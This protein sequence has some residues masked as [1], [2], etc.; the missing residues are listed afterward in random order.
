MVRGFMVCLAAL[1]GLGVAVGRVSAVDHSNEEG[2]KVIFDGK[3]MDGWKVVENPQSFT[4]QDGAMVAKG[5]RAHAFYVGDDKPFRN[6]ELKVDVMTKENSNGG[7]FFHT[8]V[9]ETGWPNQG[10]EVQ[11]NNTFEKDPR[12]TGSLYSVKDVMKVSPVGDNVWYTE[13]I[14][15]NGPKVTV[16]VEGK[17]VV[18]WT[19]EK[20]VAPGEKLKNRVGEGTFAL[21][22]HDPGSTV[23]YKNIRVKRLPD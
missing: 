11:V 4:L 23:Y 9:Q 16:K 10:F 19:D 13:H 18:E 22:A 3:S 21:Q 20:G 12:K 7:I 2:F 1:L 15:V 8:A 6:F 14:I 5:P 17:T